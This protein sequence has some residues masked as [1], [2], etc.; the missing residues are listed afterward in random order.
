MTRASGPG[1]LT[2][3]VRALGARR[4]LAELDFVL[5]EDQVWSRRARSTATVVRCLTGSLWVT[6]EGDPLDHILEAGD[7]FR[8]PCPGVVAIVALAPARVL[9]GPTTS[10]MRDVGRRRA[11]AAGG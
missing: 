10:L 6:C 8:T 5:R 4:D 9:V 2:R 11:E 7:A 1:L 3:I